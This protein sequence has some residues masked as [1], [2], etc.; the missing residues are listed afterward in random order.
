MLEI[1]HWLEITCNY[2]LTIQSI[3]GLAL[4]GLY[5]NPLVL[6]HFIFF[7]QLLNLVYTN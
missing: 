4:L 6:Y 5:I 2:P 7:I 1:C 3:L